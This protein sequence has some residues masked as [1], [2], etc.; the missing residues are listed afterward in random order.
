MGSSPLMKFYKKYHFKSALSGKE[1][2]IIRNKKI[3]ERKIMSLVRAK[4]S[5][6]SRSITYR[7]SMKV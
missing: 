7:A 3:Y 2:D 6:S 1:K 5:K 4:N